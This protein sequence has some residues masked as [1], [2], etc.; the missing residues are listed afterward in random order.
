MVRCH[1]QCLEISTSG[2]A[3]RMLRQDLRMSLLPSN[4]RHR[5][6]SSVLS[7]VAEEMGRTDLIPTVTDW[8]KSTFANWVSI[9]CAWWLLII[10]TSN[11]KF[12]PSAP[13]QAAYETAWGGMVNQA[14]ALNV[15]VDFG[16]GF[17]N[18]HHFHYGY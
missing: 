6:Y 4:I 18:D 13:T 15:F 7:L 11:L 10:L 17:Y 16:N 8:L 12:D 3:L 2:V 1:L 5:R 9:H 14:G